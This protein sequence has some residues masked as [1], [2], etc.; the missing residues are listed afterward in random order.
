M[1][2]SAAMM[3]DGDGDDDVDDDD[4]VEHGGN[5]GALLRQRL[6]Q[7]SEVMAS[8]S[9]LARNRHASFAVS[10]APR[11]PLALSSLR[12]TCRMQS[13]HPAMRV[14]LRAAALEARNAFSNNDN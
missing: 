1:Q 4:A 11:A 10:R 6:V 13:L 9:S 8:I 3:A 12:A 5:D 2:A 14:A 7:A